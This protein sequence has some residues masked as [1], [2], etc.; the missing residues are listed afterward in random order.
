MEEGS[1]DTP[2][3]ACARQEFTMKPLPVAL[4][5]I[6]ALTVASLAVALPFLAAFSDPDG[7]GAEPN[8]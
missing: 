7:G 5:V 6:A 8:S 3:P 2:M 1:R 4:L